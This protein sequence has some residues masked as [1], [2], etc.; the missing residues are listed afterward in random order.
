M[1]VQDWAA[2]IA[3]SLQDLW[4][5]ALAALANIVGAL[6]VL[7]I[8]LIV[9]HYIGLLVE[10]VISLIKLDRALSGLGLEHYFHK[11]GLSINSAMFF[12]KLAYWFLLVVF[13]LAASDILGFLAL[14]DFLQQVLLYVPNVV[15]AVLIMLAAVVIA[16]FLRRLV[17]VS[18]K[19]A[20]LFGAS[21]VG[22]LTW[23]AVVIFGFFAALTQL[24][25]AVG[26]INSIV[27]GFVAMLALAGGIAFGIG[28]KDY[29]AYLISKLRENVEH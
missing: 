8:G 21:F 2:V 10:R 5:G 3:G 27:T 23:W 19:G 20:E 13:F 25:I 12:R 6:I 16:N 15:V 29:A 22:S 14:S 11:A 4:V 9:A 1:A 17:R 24:G 18:V 28:G 7:I 26:L